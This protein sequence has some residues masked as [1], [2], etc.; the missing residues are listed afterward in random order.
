[1]ISIKP[2]FERQLKENYIFTEMGIFDGLNYSKD[3]A[4]TSDVND[5]MENSEKMKKYSLKTIV[6]NY[7]DN[8]SF[9][10]IINKLN[11]STKSKLN[12]E[13]SVKEYSTG[14]NGSKITIKETKET[15]ID[16]NN[17]ISYEIAF[18]YE[19]KKEKNLNK[20]NDEQI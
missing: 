11:S 7:I 6:K 12:S 18:D 10:F 14:E 17:R 5:M 16:K 8:L 2:N 20:I 4:D 19:D 13:Q 15:I 3:S 1:M 9:L